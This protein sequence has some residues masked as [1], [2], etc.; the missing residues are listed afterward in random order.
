MALVFDSYGSGQT[1]VLL[2]GIFK[3]THGVGFISGMLARHGL[4]AFIAYGV[5]VGEIVAPLL[6]IVGLWTRVAALVIAFDLLTAIVLARA[7]DV[8]K[9]NPMGGAWAVEAEALYVVGALALALA[10]GGR[11]AIG[12]GRR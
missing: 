7:G 2:H 3:V 9:L 10:G 12:G 1:L 6:L 11:Y 8:G 5:Y 4:P